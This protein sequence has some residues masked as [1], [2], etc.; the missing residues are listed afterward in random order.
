MANPGQRARETA[1]GVAALGCVRAGGRGGA[2]QV[3]WK[4]Q[5]FALR[6][7]MLTASRL[8]HSDAYVQC[9]TPKIG[10]P[11]VAGKWSSQAAPSRRVILISVWRCMRAGGCS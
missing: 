3:L 1:A 5:P 4:L 6:E 10:R 8:R 7:F 11:L 9:D 2:A